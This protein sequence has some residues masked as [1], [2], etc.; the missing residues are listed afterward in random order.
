MLP[1]IQ[2]LVTAVMLTYAGYWRRRQSKRRAATWEEMIARLRPNN[3][4]GFDEVATR[5]L[6]GTGINATAQDI[7][8][9]IDGAKGLWAMYNNAGVLIQIAEY[10]TDHGSGVP[11][12]LLEGLKSDAFQIRISVLMSLAQHA[13]SRSGV[14]ACVNAHRASETY[15]NMLARLT[16]LFQEHSAMLFPSFLEAM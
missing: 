1:M 15:S 11:E 3:D 9:R 5:Y 12:E 10:A 14:G 4:F 6:Y 8:G 2:V 16:M 13:F 7:W